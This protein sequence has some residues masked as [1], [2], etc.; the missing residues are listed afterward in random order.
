MST[1]EKSNKK[2][3]GVNNE[4]NSPSY[5]PLLTPLHHHHNLIKKN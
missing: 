1:K 3:K 4:N 5:F 2:E